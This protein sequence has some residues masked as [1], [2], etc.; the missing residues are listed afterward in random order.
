[1]IKKQ[2]L[3]LKKQKDKILQLFYIPFL[4]IS[5]K[6]GIIIMEIEERGRMV[7]VKKGFLTVIV[8]V[9]F[10]S[11]GLLTTF[12]LYKN[13]DNFMTLFNENSVFTS[14]AVFEVHSF[15]KKF[16][17][18]EDK[19]ASP[20]E[21]KK[22]ENFSNVLFFLLSSIAVV[23]ADKILI[24]I[25]MVVFIGLFIGNS[26][27]NLYKYKEEYNLLRAKFYLWWCLK[28]LTPVQKC[29]LNRSDEFDINPISKVWSFILHG[30]SPRLLR[31]IKSAGFFYV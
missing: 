31:R 13:I 20:L 18:F 28:F 27:I 30:T 16:L 6:I 9:V 23:P 3:F 19:A 21:D 1:M 2:L 8:G 24:L 29:I 4:T 22:D 5:H 15:I 12:R 25:L 17:G 11:F 26:T 7:K 14:G 10:L